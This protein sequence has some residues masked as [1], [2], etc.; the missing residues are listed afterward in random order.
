[1]VSLKSSMAAV[2]LLAGAMTFST[3]GNAIEAPGVA[4]FPSTALIQQVR[5]RYDPDRYGYRHRHGYV[6]YRYR[7]YYGGGLPPYGANTVITAPP[8]SAGA[9]E[10]ENNRRYFCEYAPSRC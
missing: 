2:S 10:Q 8:G 1:M 7:R 5:S 6:G 4:P 9:A 3:G